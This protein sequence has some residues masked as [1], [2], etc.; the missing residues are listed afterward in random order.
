MLKCWRLSVP[1]LRLSWACSSP[2][3][4]IYKQGLRYAPSEQYT[5]LTLENV[6]NASWINCEFMF[7]DQILTK[8][9]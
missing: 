4:S 1:S 2:T 6:W 7:V 9:I 8:N 3:T 5:T